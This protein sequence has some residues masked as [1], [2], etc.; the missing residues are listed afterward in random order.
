MRPIFLICKKKGLTRAL[1]SFS[2]SHRANFST[3]VRYPDGETMTTRF[4]ALLLIAMLAAALVAAP[5]LAADGSGWNMR[6]VIA[7]VSGQNE[8]ARDA[9]VA[10][11]EAAPGAQSQADVRSVQLDPSPSGQP[12]PFFTPKGRS[13]G[14]GKTVPS[15]RAEIDLSFAPLV[16]ETAPAVVN[17]YAARA[18][19]QRRS[20]FA[21]DPFFSQFF[22]QRQE[23]MRP[24]MQASLGSG[25]ILD[26][27]GLVVTNNHVVENADEVKV[28]LSDGREFDT[29]VL[30]K[31]EKVDLAI[32]KIQS[33]E[34]FAT[35]PLADSDE[36]ETG[37]LVLAIGN[38][39]GIGQTVT[40]GIVSALARNHI[41][42]DDFGFFIQ[43]DAAINPGNS[44]GA[45]IDMKGRLVGVNTAI[46]SRSGGSNG[47]GFAIPPTWSRVSCARPR[48][49]GRSSVP[50]SARASPRSRRTSP[51]RSASKG[52]RARWCRD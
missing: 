16:R 34:T 39:F 46:F 26:T 52:R 22:G 50:M 35:L 36:L 6:G 33:D 2:P 29:K 43:T 8:P 15:G 32:L 47:I 49:A 23:Q 4:A 12:V 20:P 45:L 9:G 37:D 24:R 18:V 7:S 25:V 31:D 21:D 19:P 11:V 40:N 42:V 13:K 17:V 1:F 30:L 48:P 10:A 27:S 41:G 5:S 3:P 51:M 38:P 28:S 44:G 14:D